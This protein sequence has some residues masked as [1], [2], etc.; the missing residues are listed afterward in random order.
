[1]TSS[2]RALRTVPLGTTGMRITRVGFGAWGA[3]CGGRSAYVRL[4]NSTLLSA[5]TVIA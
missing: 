1:M 2:T 4:V 5:W 3:V